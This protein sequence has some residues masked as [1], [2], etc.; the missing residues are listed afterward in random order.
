LSL[1]LFGTLAEGARGKELGSRDDPLGL[2]AHIRIHF[3]STLAVGRGPPH[4]QWLFVDKRNILQY[5]LLL[6]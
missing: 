6:L 1:A 5:L 4:R 3:C 2:V